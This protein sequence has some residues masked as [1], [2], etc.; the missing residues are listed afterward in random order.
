MERGDLDLYKW[1]WSSYGWGLLLGLKRFS[2]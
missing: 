2:L 1:C